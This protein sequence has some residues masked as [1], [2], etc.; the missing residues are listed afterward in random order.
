MFLC[1]IS[2]NSNDILF[3]KAE[4]WVSFKVYYLIF[5]F[6]NL[7]LESGKAGKREKAKQ[8]H[9]DAESQDTEMPVR[10]ESSTVMGWGEM[11]PVTR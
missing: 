10:T 6:I 4:N 7:K 8:A 11:G 2:G 1:P 3:F 5:G 9:L